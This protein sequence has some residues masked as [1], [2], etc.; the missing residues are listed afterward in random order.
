M[1]NWE[2]VRNSLEQWIAWTQIKQTLKKFRK[3]WDQQLWVVPSVVS[4]TTIW[5][6]KLVAGQ[7]DRE[8]LLKSTELSPLTSMPSLAETL[9][10][11]PVLTSEAVRHED[12]CNLVKDIFI[13]SHPLKTTTKEKREVVFQFQLHTYVIWVGQLCTAP[14]YRAI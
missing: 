5:A 4:G 9:Q 12:A 10:E 14:N 13:T 2:E 3:M 6:Q 11:W 7:F 8:I 1:E